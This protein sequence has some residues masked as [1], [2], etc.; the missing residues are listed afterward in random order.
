MLNGKRRPMLMYTLG[1]ASLEC[2]PELF[3]AGANAVRLTFSFGSARLQ[4][5]RARA[6]RSV[7]AEL[8]CPCIIVADLAGEKP[9]LGTFS[10]T[11]S[12]PVHTGD[13][14]QFFHGSSGEPSQPGH[15]LF[16]VTND[17]FLAEL[18]VGA[19]VVVG[20]GAV[21]LLVKQTQHE[22]VECQALTGG[23]IDQTRGLTVQGAPFVPRAL[24]EKDLGDLD[25]IAGAGVFDMVALSFVSD[26]HDVRRA[27]AVLRARSCSACI[28]AKIETS[29]GIGN[30]DAI[31]AEADMIMAATASTIN[32]CKIF[33]R[34]FLLLC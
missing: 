20:D 22:R 19:I 24:T 27:R 25:S 18:T 23:V 34:I 28:I 12:I 13:A 29:S 11:P 10:T 16:P 3:R 14:I 2:A 17:R 33:L 9:R 32:K 26:P 7:A 6:L 4:E 30:L 21:N 1:P 31:G 15:L 8:G 5:T